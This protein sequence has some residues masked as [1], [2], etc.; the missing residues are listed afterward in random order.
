MLD[1]RPTCELC[2]TALDPVLDDARICTYECTFCAKCATWDLLGICPNCAGELVMRPRRPPD[3]LVKHPASSIIVHHAH[4]LEAHQGAVRA[5]LESGDLP[6]QVWTVAFCNRRPANGTG[7]GYAA[8]AEQ[9]DA[10]AAAQP[11]YIGIDAVRSDSGAGITVSR[12]SSIAAMVSWRK[13]TTHQEAQSTGRDRWYDWYRSD[14]ARVDR[15]SEF[16]REVPPDD[17]AISLS[18]RVAKGQ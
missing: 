7:D 14:V 18:H 15:S 5:R 1:L 12:W 8:T 17:N 6:E 9:M 16:R 13:V 4:D 11:G 2:T 3:H 10:L